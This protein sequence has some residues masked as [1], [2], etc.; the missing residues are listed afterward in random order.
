MTNRR[1]FIAISAGAMLFLNADRLTWAQPA[2]RRIGW[3]SPF[4][5]ADVESFLALL[6]PELD[7][8]G[9]SDGRNLVMDVRM[10]EGRNDLLPSLA[11]ELVVQGPDLIIVQ[12]LPATRALMQATRSIPIVMA[13]VA[14][15][16]EY[17]IVASFGRP[18][19][20]VTGS[21]YPADESAR[22]LLQL[23]KEAAPRL[24]SVALFLN[25]SNE[26]AP[27]LTRQVVEDAT[28]LGMQAQIVPVSAKSDFE[29]AFAAIRKANSQSIMLPPEPL[30]LANREAIGTFAHAHGLPVVIVGT[31]GAL[32][33]NGLMAFGPSRPAFAE[34]TARYVDRILRGARPGDLAV[35]Q[36]T[37]FDLVISLKTARALGLPISQ[38]LLLRASEV[39]E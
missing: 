20:N 5:R 21:S 12:S 36:P 24:T 2:P 27:A 37:R 4:S 6:R 28:A 25:P 31:R 38:A 15:P 3:L 14:Y 33:P 18:G 16:V 13:G 7:K 26:A 22:K 39:V 32:P 30:I 10:T 1:T 29:S 8:L 23:L 34:I 19:G 9:W 35:E 11:A 17:G